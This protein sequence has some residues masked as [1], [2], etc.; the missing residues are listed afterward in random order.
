MSINQELPSDTLWWTQQQ[1]HTPIMEQTPANTHFHQ[2]Q[3]THTTPLSFNLNQETETEEMDRDQEE[4]VEQVVYVQKDSMFEKPLT[5][6]DVGKL[7]R[8]VIPKQHAEKYFPLAANGGG[9]SVEKGLLLSFEDE[10][11]K[12][13]RFRY[14]YWNSSQSYVL[15]KGWSRFV[16]EKR[17]DAGD[18]VVFERSRNESDRF[19]VGWR[20][21]NATPPQ[22]ENTV[23]QSGSS[24]GAGWTRVYYSGYP[25]PTVVSNGQ[26][27]AN[28]QPQCLHAPGGGGL[29]GMQNQTTAGG[30][31]SKTVRLF[32]VNLE[33]QSD[34]PPGVG[35]D[36]SNQSEDQ[37]QTQV[38]HQHYNYSNGGGA[39]H[40]S[41]HHS[42]LH[43]DI[44]FSRDVN[45]MR[46]YQG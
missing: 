4:S 44:N 42:S 19:F 20:R 43:M 24:G 8:L 37:A 1:H 3:N 22:S 12:T 9:E 46:F 13:W 35:A 27:V 15:T 2:R 36:G 14:S 23:A 28:Y 38:H 45:Q 39:A 21:R 5:P 26:A 32:G 16:K 29:G 10:S 25:Y 11:G 34:E 41:K 33:C 6:S 40:V 31:N 17:L 30:G 18:V 7:N